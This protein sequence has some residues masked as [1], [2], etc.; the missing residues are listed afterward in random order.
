MDRNRFNR[1]VRPDVI[2]IPIGDCGVAF[3]RL[4]LDGWHR[5]GDITTRYP[6]PELAEL[7][8]VAERVVGANSRESP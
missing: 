4:E 6:A 8:A 5:N 1:D 2:E 3:Y 7:I